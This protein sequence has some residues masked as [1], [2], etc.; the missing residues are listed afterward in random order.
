MQEGMAL[1]NSFDTHTEAALLKSYLDHNGIESE[2]VNAHI[3]SV[4]HLYSNLVGGIKVYVKEADLEKATELMNT[5][6]EPTGDVPDE[7]KSSDKPYKNPVRLKK[8]IITLL[9]F[10]VPTY[11]FYYVLKMLGYID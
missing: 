10:G 11:I 6:A 8:Q 3:S 1:L 7:L 2:L 5:S 9:Y 4:N